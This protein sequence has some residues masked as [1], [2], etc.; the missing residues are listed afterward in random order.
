MSSVTEQRYSGKILGTSEYYDHERSVRASIIRGLTIN[1]QKSS[2]T[3]KEFYWNEL[4]AE[5]T[6]FIDAGIKVH[7]IKLKET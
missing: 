5:E 7:N 1:V 4:E 2:N 6:V 3:L